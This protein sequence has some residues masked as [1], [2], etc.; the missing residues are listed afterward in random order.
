[1]GGFTLL[2]LLVS[3]I[4]TA[5][6]LAGLIQ[7]F[8]IQGRTHAREEQ[9]VGMDENLRVAASMIVDS[10][11]NSGY[12]APSNVS[13]WITWVSGMNANP[14]LTQSGSSSIPD[15]IS[16]AGCFKE[17][18]A[19]L[20]G[21]YVAGVTGTTLAVTPTGTLS[22]DLDTG[23]KSLIR[24]GEGTTADFASV[25]GA[26]GSTVN[27]GA[28]LSHDHWGS[29]SSGGA[30]ICRVDVITYSVATDSSTGVPRLMRDDNQGAGAQPVAEGISN[31]KIT[32]TSPLKYTITLS[33]RSELRDP[34]SGSW[35]TR[36]LQATVRLRNS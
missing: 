23:S 19:T 25:T 27:I 32:F 1:V 24:V 28:A 33:G 14:K 35:L 18:V 31:M 15:T 34:I 3:M 16:V 30:N 13:T 7:F 8:L 12:A 10:L 17:P 21:Q 29:T 11:R 5:I 20:S 6:M 36:N 2:E 4:A 26:S 22:N 9:R